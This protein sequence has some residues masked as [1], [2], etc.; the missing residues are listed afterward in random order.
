MTEFKSCNIVIWRKKLRAFLQNSLGKYFDK[1][2][3]HEVEFVWKH[4]KERKN[5][6]NDWM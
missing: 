3:A 6:L 5:L 2:L 1:F 4:K